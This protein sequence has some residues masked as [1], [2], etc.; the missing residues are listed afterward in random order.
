MSTNLPFPP[1]PPSQ[2]RDDAREI[3]AAAET[4]AVS[5]PGAVLSPRL[6]WVGLGVA[7]LVLVALIV[8]LIAAETRPPSAGA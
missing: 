3:T 6:F 2:G 4:T 5:T 7:V 1:P 8:R